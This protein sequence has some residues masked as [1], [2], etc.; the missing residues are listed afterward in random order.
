MNSFRQISDDIFCEAFDTT[1]TQVLNEESILRKVFKLHKLMPQELP[2]FDKKENSVV[3]YLSENNNLFTTVKGNK[4][5]LP[6]IDIFDKIGISRYSS[7]FDKIRELANLILK[8]ETD[9]FNHFF[10]QIYIK[11]DDYKILSKDEID[12]Y[13]VIFTDDDNYSSESVNVFKVNFLENSEYLAIKGIYGNIAIRQH[14]CLMSD[15]GDLS[16]GKSLFYKE[17]VGI[18]LGAESICRFVDESKCINKFNFI[19]GED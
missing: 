16:N 11:Y 13:D 9:L 14:K 5:I 12:Q 2:M 8:K 19:V 15:N 3:E 18:M 4:V 17:D 1:V 6:L 7:N 10:Q